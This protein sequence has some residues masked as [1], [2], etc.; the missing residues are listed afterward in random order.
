MNRSEII[1]FLILRSIGNFLLLFAIFGV[2]ATFGPALYYEVS[3]KIVQVRGIKYT[4]AD[5]KT[6]PLGE[7][8]KKQQAENSQGIN[9]GFAQVL[10]GPKEQILIPKD[11][12]FSIL[13]PRLGAS[14][15]VFSN[16]DPS[17]QNEFL[18]ILQNGVAHAKGTV[19]PGMAGNI[20]L[21]AHSTDNFWDV[22]R[23]N[24]V[25]YL[26]KDLKPGDDII[27][28]F[29]NQRHNYVVTESRVVDAKDIS[30]ITQAKTGKEKLILQTCWPP[31]TTWKRLLVFAKPK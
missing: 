27:V 22:G 10:A 7:I 23:Y 29:E 21:F 26:L 20:Y 28:F 19:F 13:I 16:I 2:L 1:R 8:L 18:P 6:S 4:V 31:G 11:T 24:A 25:F 12:N 3:F 14:T 17:N 9:G 30:Y 15:K 5:N